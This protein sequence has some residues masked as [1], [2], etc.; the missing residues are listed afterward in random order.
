MSSG[1]TTSEIVESV[2]SLGIVLGSR[3]RPGEEF[4]CSESKVAADGESNRIKKKGRTWEARPFSSFSS[5]LLLLAAHRPKRLRGDR[6]VGRRE[7]GERERVREALER[8][9][10]SPDRGRPVRIR[11]DLRRAE[12]AYRLR[13]DT[14]CPFLEE[15]TVASLS[16]EKFDVWDSTRLPPLLV[17]SMVAE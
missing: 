10:P 8:Y 7:A 9:S 16:S 17:Q 4:D 14:H 3:E 6:N 13:R 1:A 12:S 11:T 15:A 5:V 2:L